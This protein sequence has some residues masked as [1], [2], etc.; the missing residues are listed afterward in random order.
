MRCR[1]WFRSGSSAVDEAEWD[2]EVSVARRT[3]AD[4]QSVGVA[5]F[6]RL[7]R[8]ARRASG[9]REGPRSPLIR[10]MLPCSGPNVKGAR[11]HRGRTTEALA[12]WQISPSITSSFPSVH[13]QPTPSTESAD[14]AL[15]PVEIIPGGIHACRLTFCGRQPIHMSRRC[16]DRRATSCPEGGVTSQKVPPVLVLASSSMKLASRPVIEA[17]MDRLP[18]GRDQ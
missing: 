7:K 8:T 6:A 3:R 10:A 1:I 9:E 15:Q 14:S 12:A 16:Y 11:V 17:A 18:E 4:S 2:E 13:R 5:V